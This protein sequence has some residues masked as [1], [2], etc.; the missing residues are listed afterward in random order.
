MIPQGEVVELL[1]ALIRNA[2]V[3]DGSPD[4]GH[5]HRAVSTLADY[6]G[7]AGEIVEPHPGRQSVVYRVPGRTP[8]APGLTLLPHTDVVPVTPSGWSHDPFGGE[9]DQGFVWGRGAIDM[10]NLTSSMAA[11]FKRYLTGEL[12]PLPGD[13]VYAAVA[14]EEAG[15]ALG[16]AWIAEHR[17]D[18]VDTPYLLTEVATPPLHAAGGLPVTVAEKGPA[19]RILRT[20]GTPGHGSQP[21]GTDNALIPLA[22]AI[23]KLVNSPSPVV[24]SDEWRTFIAGAGLD[25]ALVAQ[26]SDADL[27]DEGIEA[28]AAIDPDLARWA[29]ACTHVTVAPTAL[30]SGSKHNVIPDGG[31]A[32]LDLRVVPGQDQATADDHLRKSL[33]PRLS[34]E[35]E[36][37]PDTSFDPTASSIANPLWDAVGDAAETLTGS[38]S[39]LPMLI[40]FTTDARFFRR[41]GVVAYGVGLFDD[42]MQFGD[43][44]R[45]FHGHDERVSLGSVARTTEMLALTLNRFGARTARAIR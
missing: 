3:N 9:V 40:P 8:G 12:P 27:V 33:G 38:R 18:L 39:L 15:G 32:L 1:Q 10:L 41:R 31:E 30:H 11:V 37:V 28:L 24:I 21:Y 20:H 45:L 16:A 7:V 43:M 22:E 17:P 29:H 26:L 44:M 25:D 36:V 6:F 34:E 23:A 2:C 42:A 14:D 35:I 19:W 4:S 5:E 13:L